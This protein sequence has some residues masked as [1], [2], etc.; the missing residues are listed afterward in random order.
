MAAGLPHFATGYMRSW[1]RDTMISLRGLMLVTGRFKEAEELLLGFAS[2]VRHGLIPNLLDS[3]SR[4]ERKKRGRR[5]IIR[6]CLE[7]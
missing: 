6:V 3:V 2:S 1:G 5:I 7:R 4:E